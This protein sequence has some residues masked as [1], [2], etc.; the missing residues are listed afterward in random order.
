ME[1]SSGVNPLLTVPAGDSTSKGGISAMCTLELL[2]LNRLGY[3][4]NKDGWGGVF[5]TIDVIMLSTLNRLGYFANKDGWGG[6]F[7]L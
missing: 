6:V 1:I 3:F 7:L 4:A 2:T 5:F